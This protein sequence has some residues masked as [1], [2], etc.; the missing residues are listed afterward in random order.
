MFKLR[1][2]V[3][4]KCDRG[5]LFRFHLNTN[6]ITVISPPFPVVSDIKMSSNPLAKGSTVNLTVS[7]ILFKM[8]WFLEVSEVEG[9][10]LVRDT[11]LKGPFKAW[12]HDHI[13]EDIPGGTRM[14]DE[15]RFIPPFGLLG[16]LALPFVYLQLHLMFSDRHRRTKKYFER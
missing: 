15:V 11:Q 9:N 7:F 2:S 16:L 12:V 4:I 8:K 13:F 6:N 3:D 1:K 10:S 5:E 14:T